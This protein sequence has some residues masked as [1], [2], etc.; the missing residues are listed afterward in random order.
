MGC[1]GSAQR[2]TVDHDVGQSQMRDQIRHVAGD[3]RNTQVGKIVI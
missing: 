2:P 3:G 1:H